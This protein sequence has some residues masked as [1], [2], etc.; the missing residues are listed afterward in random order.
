MPTVDALRDLLTRRFHLVVFTI[1]AVYCALQCL[2]IAH[3]PLVMDE[4]DGA[5]EA[6]HL[7]HAVPYRDFTPYKTVLGYDVELLG[8]F[9]ARSVWPRILAIKTEIV[10][11][12]CAVLFAAALTLS[13][14]V[15]RSAV[16][17]ALALLVLCSTFLERSSE[18]RVDMLTAWAGLWSLLALL[19]RRPAWAGAL[20]GVSFLVSQ[21]GAF[22]IVAGAVALGI[23]WLLERKNVTRFKAIVTYCAAAIGAI[24]A[25]IV[26]W[27]VATS[28]GPVLRATFVGGAQAAMV[29]SY[30]I[31]S[32]YWE[33]IIGRDPA[34]FALVAVAFVVTAIRG[35]L[36]A[37]LYTGV[38]LV[39]AALYS[40]PWPY[41]FV[42]IF[43]TLFVLQ[44]FFFDRV[45]WRTPVAIAVIALALIY[46]L[47]RIGVVMSRHNDYQGYT[48]DLA[49]AL[50]GPHDTYLAGTDIVH[51]HEQWPPELS[52]LGMPVLIDL[53]KRPPGFVQ[54]VVERIDQ[55]PPKLLVGN[56]RLDGLPKPIRRYLHAHYARISGSVFL[57]APE[58][59][60]G[61]A[62]IVFGG[63]YRTSAA[64]AV[65]GIPHVAGDQFEL[66][67]GIHR[68]ESE[69]RVRLRLLPRLDLLDPRYMSEQ[70]L[71]PNPYSY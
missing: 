1:V 13:R 10:L 9:A 35:N 8:T 11:I 32:L 58:V 28:F 50:L 59:S 64:V 12:N 20:A 37:C 24:A 23:E 2:Y 26:I 49:S 68:I 36:L 54:G 44:A 33:Q 61:N 66:A 38:V 14:M 48:V 16:A 71:Y 69:T 18:L 47:R 34:Y 3:L 31:R 22:Y 42:I 41:F 30:D 56:Y 46:P 53:G 52:R 29:G 21:K 40:Q 5:Y 25:Y 19:R 55:R 57:Y 45:E 60:S 15:S 39:Q 65:D 67:P 6:Y 63:L 17:A 4:F 62:R 70:D 27:G 7:R 43:P 51:D